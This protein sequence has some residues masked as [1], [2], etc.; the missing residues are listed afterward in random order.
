M[1]PADAFEQSGRRVRIPALDRHE[2]TSHLEYVGDA[3]T[4]TP[5]GLEMESQVACLWRAHT[6]PH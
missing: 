2:W 3:E 6:V 1:S 4:S 5:L